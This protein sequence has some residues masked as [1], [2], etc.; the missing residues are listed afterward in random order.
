[1]AAKRETVAR[2]E[3]AARRTGRLDGRGE[4]DGIG[5]FAEEDG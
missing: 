4:V 2:G 1:M 5:R 3:E